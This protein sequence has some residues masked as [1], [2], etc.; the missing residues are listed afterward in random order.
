MRLRMAAAVLTLA[1]ATTTT[2]A[3]AQAAPPTK[4]MEDLDR[5]LISVRSGSGNLVSLRLLGTD[6]DGVAFNVYR[7]S[8]RGSPSPTARTTPAWETWTATGSTRSS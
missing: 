5:G 1:A 4:Q 2:V 6:P 3:P 7:G 8:T